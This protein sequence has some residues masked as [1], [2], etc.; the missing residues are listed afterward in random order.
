[1]PYYANCDVG[2]DHCENVQYEY[3]SHEDGKQRFRMNYLV[4]ELHL[5]TVLFHIISAQFLYIAGT[6]KMPIEEMLNATAVLIP[7]NFCKVSNVATMQNNAENKADPEI[8]E[9]LNSTE[10]WYNGCTQRNKYL[11]VT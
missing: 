6:H 1:M 4:H 5:L 3:E 8:I 10:S 9:P 7:V 11:H 2:Q